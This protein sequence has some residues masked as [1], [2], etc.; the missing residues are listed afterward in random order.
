MGRPAAAIILSEEEREGLERWL[1]WRSGS[2]GMHV[3]AGIVLDCAAGLSGAEIAE[4]HRT[5]QQTVG[6]WRGRFS[7]E[8][9]SGLSDAPRSR[10][11]RRHGDERVQEVLDATLNRRRRRRRTGPCAA[12]RKNWACPGTSFIASGAPSA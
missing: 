9:Q 5:S 3:I 1:R 7:R 12:C 11:P 4:R 2:S 10:Q 8:R 6:K